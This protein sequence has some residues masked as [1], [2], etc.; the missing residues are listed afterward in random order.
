MNVPPCNV[1][2]AQDKGVCHS[3]ELVATGSSNGSGGTSSQAGP[4][5]M[6][7]MLSTRQA[8]QNRARAAQRMRRAEDELQS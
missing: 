6:K 4:P 3:S 1:S 8:G 2:I 7:E 5:T